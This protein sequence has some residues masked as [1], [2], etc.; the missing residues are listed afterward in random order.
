V[1]LN[2][3]SSAM[4]PFGPLLA[5]VAAAALGVGF[6]GV[7]DLLGQLSHWR[8]APR[9]YLAA[10]L[11]PVGVTAT[12]AAITTVSAGG[13]LVQHRTLD[14]AQI[15]ATFASTVILVGLFEEV[16]WRGYALPALG[17]RL[18]DLRAAFVIGAVWSVW[19]LPLLISDPTGQRPVVQF[20]IMAMAQS[21]FFTWLYRSSRSGLLL[22]ILGHAAVDT[23]ARFVLPQFTATDYYLVW[24]WQS[25]IWVLAAIAAGVSVSGVRRD[26]EPR[27]YE[28]VA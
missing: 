1:L 14:W 8:A 4:V 10:L 12:A 9:W 17:P 16:G 18:G 2:P 13:V 23:V 15:A 6:R 24:W 5:A 28:R 3:D 27:A 21:V 25:A 26:Q 20:L 19:H 22:V 11:T 7:S